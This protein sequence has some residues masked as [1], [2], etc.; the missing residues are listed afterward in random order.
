MDN[1]DAL[2]VDLETALAVLLLGVLSFSLDREVPNK[3]A[4]F[5]FESTLAWRAL[6]KLLVYLSIASGSGNGFALDMGV[7]ELLFLWGFPTGDM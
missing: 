4:V 3:A 5:A 6:G 1:D 2:E 7:E